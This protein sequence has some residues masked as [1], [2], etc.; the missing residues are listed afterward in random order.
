VEQLLRIRQLALDFG[1]FGAGQPLAALANS[2]LLFVNWLVNAAISK[3][4]SS[5]LLVNQPLNF[6]R[7]VTLLCG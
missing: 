3:K 7:G 5:N 4:I 2:V 6:A 1:T